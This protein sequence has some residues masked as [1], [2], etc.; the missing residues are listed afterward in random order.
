M[1]TDIVWGE[2]I[3]Q[4][5]LLQS[6]VPVGSPA[7][8]ALVQATAQCQLRAG[9]LASAF[10]SER[11]LAAHTPPGAAPCVCVESPLR[12]DTADGLA[13]N[14]AYADACLYDCLT[15][16]EAPFLGHL[17]YPRVLDDA[18]K[19]DRDLGIDAHCAWLRQAHRVAVYVDFG[20]T[21]GMQK[22]VDLARELRIPVVE[23]DLGPDW[24]TWIRAARPTAGFSDAQ[25]AS[26]RPESHVQE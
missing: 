4:L 24:E 25:C 2:V 19:R 23:R 10:A 14:V 22:A 21:L 9:Q 7:Y 1:M 6:T 11:P 5:R 26:E 8:R 3:A 18:R 16:G 13:R 17:L 12:A 15:R 20:I